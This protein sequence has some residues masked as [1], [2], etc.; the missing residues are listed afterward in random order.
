MV[1]GKKLSLVEDVGH[2]LKGRGDH[3]ITD[4]G[5]HQLRVR[6]LKRSPRPAQVLLQT[7]ARKHAPRPVHHLPAINQSIDATQNLVLSYNRQRTQ[8]EMVR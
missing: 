7:A 8:T 4:F 5:F 1:R 6:P 3:P 2:E